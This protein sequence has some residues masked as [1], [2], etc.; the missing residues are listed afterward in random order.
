MICDELKRCRVTPQC[1]DKKRCAECRQV[2]AHRKITSKEKNSSYTLL[3]PDKV[4]VIVFH[5]DGGIIYNEE[6]C[7]KY[8]YIY[9]ITNSEASIVIFIELKGKHYTD[10]LEQ[11]E[12][13]LK[14]FKDAFAGSSLHARII[15]TRVP[16][17][18][19]DPKSVMIE[20]SLKKHGVELRKKEKMME[21]PLKYFLTINEN[22]SN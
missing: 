22:S 14:L 1:K 10:A 18:I 5:A 3:N 2:S 6:N 13:S 8:D 12:N 16:N 11:I 9:D 4:P 21:E 17:I 15:C 20:K 7:R 19:N